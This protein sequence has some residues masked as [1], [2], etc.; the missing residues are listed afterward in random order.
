MSVRTWTTRL[1]V[2]AAAAVVGVGCS[3]D[4]GTTRTPE[5]TAALNPACQDV[6]PGEVEHLVG[7]EG[8]NWLGD[9][10]LSVSDAQVVAV[11]ADGDGFRFT[12]VLFLQAQVDGGEPVVFTFVTDSPDLT[13]GG[14]TAVGDDVT[15]GA[16]VWGD[17][18]TQG[19]DLD[20]EARAAVDEAGRC[21]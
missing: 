5:S 7:A 21:F 13:G 6:D 20:Q 14:L 1:A 19:S 15:R 9:G 4:D 18:T 10:D 11:G 8:Q 2:V 17:T 12:R 16:F 3:G